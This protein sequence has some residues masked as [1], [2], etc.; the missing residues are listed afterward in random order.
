MKDAIVEVTT[1]NFSPEKANNQLWIT[2]WEVIKFDG[3]MKLYIEWND[4]ENEEEDDEGMLPSLKNWDTVFGW[5]F[6]S[7]SR[8]FKT[9]SK[10]Y[11]GITC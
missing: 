1:F 3:F 7:K 2:K 11:W 9:T 10:I 5:K 8:F 6:R 4:D